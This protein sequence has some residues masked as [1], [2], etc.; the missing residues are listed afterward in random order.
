V[1]AAR[2][3]CLEPGLASWNHFGPTSTP[4]P[5]WRFHVPRIWNCSINVSKFPVKRKTQN[6]VDVFVPRLFVV[7]PFLRNYFA[8]NHFHEPPLSRSLGN[9]N[10]GQEQVREVPGFFAADAQ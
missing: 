6:V 9:L 10:D 3:F 5:A 8:C 7:V 4:R 1:L 2:I